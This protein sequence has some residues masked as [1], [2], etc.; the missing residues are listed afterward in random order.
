MAYGL[1]IGSSCVPS[2]ETTS[3]TQRAGAHRE[4]GAWSR[5]GETIPGGVGE[6]PGAAAWL[7]KASPKRNRASP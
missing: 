1:G 5:S 6:A 4:D 3:V 7:S 2:L